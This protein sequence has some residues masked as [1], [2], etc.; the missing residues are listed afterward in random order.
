MASPVFKTCR[1]TTTKAAKKKLR[2]PPET[3]QCIAAYETMSALSLGPDTHYCVSWNCLYGWYVAGFG[4]RPPP[5]GP[6]Q[7]NGKLWLNLRKCPFC[8]ISLQTVNEVTIE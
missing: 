4:H 1:P 7:Y 2:K 6:V 5:T 8:E 3:H